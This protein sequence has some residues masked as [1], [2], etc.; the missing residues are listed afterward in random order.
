MRPSARR[1]L[2]VDATA[3]I[4]LKL[5]AALAGSLAFAFLLSITPW[6][7]ARE[8]GRVAGPRLIPFVAVAVC[9][10][11][12]LIAWR[13]ARIRRVFA[14]GERVKGRVDQIDVTRGTGRIAFA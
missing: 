14:T 2:W 4:A 12:P 10:C 1:I 3:S 11:F 8:V 7:E 9:T 13:I 5:V 6:P